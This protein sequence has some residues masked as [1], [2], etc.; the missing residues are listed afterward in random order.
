MTPEEREAISVK[1]ELALLGDDLTAKTDRDLS[2]AG[3]HWFFCQLPENRKRIS[4]EAE[5]KGITN[6]FALWESRAGTSFQSDIE[7]H[8][9]AYRRQPRDLFTGEGMG[10][11]I[12]GM[13]EKGFGCALHCGPPGKPICRF[14]QI[15]G[16]QNFMDSGETIPEAIALA[17]VKALEGR[18]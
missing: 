6:P 11:V 3:K 9:A 8:V 15:N 7:S 1:L 14:Y 5:S 18:T 16:P 13:N 17:A 10:L 2:E 12:E 4:Q